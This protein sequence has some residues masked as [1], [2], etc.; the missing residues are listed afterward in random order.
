[1]MTT[2]LSDQQNSFPVDDKYYG[3]ASGMLCTQPEVYIWDRHPSNPRFQ[4]SYQRPNKTRFQYR[5]VH[6]FA[7]W[8]TRRLS[9]VLLSF[10]RL[11]CQHGRYMGWK[12]I[13]WRQLDNGEITPITGKSISMFDYT[14]KAAA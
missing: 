9:T 4:R 7:N 5:P 12:G 1:M 14:A 8:L 2:C 6:N 11:C 10:N 3:L 13:D